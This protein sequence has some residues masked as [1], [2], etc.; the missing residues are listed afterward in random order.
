[1][2]YKTMS[3]K[4]DETK[5]KDAK[6]FTLSGHGSIFDNVDRDDEVIEKG[7]FVESLKNIQP[8]LLWQHKTFEPIGV[9][10]KI[11]EDNKGLALD[12]KMPLND[13]LVKGRVKPQVEIGSVKTM[14]IGFRTR[15][16]EYDRKTGINY[17]KKVDLYEVSLVSISANSLAVISDYK[18][19]DKELEDA[20]TIRDMEKYLKNIGISNKKS[21]III[22][23]FKK[24]VRDD[25]SKDQ[26][27]IDSELKKLFNKM[28]QLNIG[29]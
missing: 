24:I 29:G 19:F 18:S 26:C 14:S 7:C 9:F 27:D 6:F 3:F 1:M 28:N 10:T 13:D 20:K 25:Q 17:I 2:K 8:I 12:A 5:E 11:G 23:K 15:V 21:A 4:V 22:S 16:D